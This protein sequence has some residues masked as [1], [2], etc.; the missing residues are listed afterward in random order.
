MKDGSGAPIDH[1]EKRDNDHVVGTR[2][3]FFKSAD[4]KK[5]HYHLN[6]GH[7]LLQEDLPYLSSD[8]NASFDD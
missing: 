1:G 6:K 4:F 5:Q 2:V 8:M 3:L 7:Q